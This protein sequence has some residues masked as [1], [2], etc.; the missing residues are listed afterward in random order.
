MPK[1][2]CQRIS[3]SKYFVLGYINILDK[4]LFATKILNVLVY[5]MKSIIPP[6][7]KAALKKKIDI[8]KSF[9]EVFYIIW[10][11]YNFSSAKLHVHCVSDIYKCF[12]INLSKTADSLNAVWLEVFANSPPFP[13]QS[14]HF[15][16][17]LVLRQ[18]TGST[19]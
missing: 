9:V 8:M 19:F 16:Q 6:D 14:A 4:D 13:S 7:I 17:I 12:Q 10:L 15:Q 2:C 3:F 5:E 1:I 11:I 18:V